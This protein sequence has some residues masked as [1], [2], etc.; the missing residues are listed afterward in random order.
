MTGGVSINPKELKALAEACR[1]A[2]I[3]KFKC[4]NLEFEL[5]PEAPQSAYKRA[6]AEKAPSVE[7]GPIETDELSPYETLMY[8]V[9]DPND[10]VAPTE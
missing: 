2:G 7:Q 1:K 4:G 10:A 3:S 8:S 6:K 9:R 5:A